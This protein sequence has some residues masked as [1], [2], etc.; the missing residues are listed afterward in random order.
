VPV[1][2]AYFYRDLRPAEVTSLNPAS[3]TVALLAGLLGASAVLA[4]GLSLA[5]SV[6]RRRAT[7]AVLSAIGFGRRDLR[8]TVRWQT[9]VITAVALV[10]GLPL[11]VVAGRI[12]W[13]AFADQLGAAGGPRVPLVLLGVAAIALIVLANLVGEW[14]ARSAGSARAAVLRDRTERA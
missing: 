10:V 4:L 3:R 11:G 2:N 12:A 9:N 6:R 13:T 14:P 8:R 7:Y 1:E 5:G